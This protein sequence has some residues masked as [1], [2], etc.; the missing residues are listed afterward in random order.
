MNKG[1]TIYFARTHPEVGIYEVLELHVRT[2]A[3]QYFVGTDVKSSQA[4][5]FNYEDLNKIVFYDRQKALELVLEEEKHKK[6]ISD[7]TFYEEF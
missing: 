3:E 5:L 4:F 2:V 1:D 6:I 7:E